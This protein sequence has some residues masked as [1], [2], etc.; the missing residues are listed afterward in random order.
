MGRQR[1][2]KEKEV[3]FARQGGDLSRLS[4]LLSGSAGAAMNGICPVVTAERGPYETHHTPFEIFYV[5][6]L[7]FEAR[8]PESQAGADMLGAAAR[9][10]YGR[11]G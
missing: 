4:R 7:C 1:G 3:V 6:E 2:C 8:L 11:Y 5:F 9:W 10:A